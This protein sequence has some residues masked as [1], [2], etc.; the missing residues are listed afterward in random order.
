ME[1]NQ[2]EKPVIPCVFQLCSALSEIIN[3]PAAPRLQTVKIVIGLRAYTQAAEA[4]QAALEIVD[5]ED[6][7]M[8]TA[9]AAILAALPSEIPSSLR[10]A[11]TR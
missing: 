4:M 7:N 6:R 1:T 10:N 3:D 8:D 5:A 11:L 9:K 2:P